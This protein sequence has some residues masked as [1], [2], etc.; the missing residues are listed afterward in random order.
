MEGRRGEPIRQ[1]GVK[2]GRRIAEER[3]RRVGTGAVSRRREN[4]RTDGPR[5][6]HLG[7]GILKSSRRRECGMVGWMSRPGAPPHPET[8]RF[9]GF[10]AAS[11]G[12]QPANTTPQCPHTPLK[13]P[14]ASI[15]RVLAPRRDSCRSVFPLD[16]IVPVLLLRS[17][18]HSTRPSGWDRAGGTVP[19][20]T[21]YS[22]PISSR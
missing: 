1:S 17:P 15:G 11:S 2:E 22:G 21:E 8:A 3:K 12:Q 6:L 16:W 19:T 7:A 18:V 9:Q 20:C 5:C 13:R 4:G 14:A 10:S